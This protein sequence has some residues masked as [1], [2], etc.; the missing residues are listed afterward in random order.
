VAWNFEGYSS[1][2]FR[3]SDEIIQASDEAIE[4]NPPDPDAL[5]GKEALPEQMK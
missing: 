5:E 2:K 1:V 4:I 3:R